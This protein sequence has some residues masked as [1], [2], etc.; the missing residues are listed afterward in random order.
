MNILCFVIEIIKDQK[1]LHNRMDNVSELNR[2]RVIERWNKV[3]EK[4]RAAFSNNTHETRCLKA[5]VHGYLCG[6]GSVTARK[7]KG[8]GKIHYDL[9]FYPDH[10]SMIVA[11]QK[12][13]FTL[14]RMRPKIRKAENY[15]RLSLT[16]KT[17]VTDLLNTSDFTSTRW[18]IPKWILENNAYM[19]EWLRAYFDA[20]AY[21][22]DKEIR[23]QTVNKDGIRYI[24]SGLQNFGIVP[25]IYSYKRKQKNWNENFHISIG[26]KANR[27]LF[28]KKIGFNHSIKLRKLTNQFAEIA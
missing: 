27:R 18:T 21:V 20:E 4:E 3:H 8:T 5:R 6:D 16:S 28:L 10:K 15:Y 14:Y 9:R 11:F 2:N 12:A 13:F 24:L 25:R 23:I 7:E 1:I 17:V 22:G 19:R 26:T